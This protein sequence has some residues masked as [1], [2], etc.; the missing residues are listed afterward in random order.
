MPD[1]AM[2]SEPESGGVSPLPSNLK[3]RLISGSVLA[4]I[5]F[6]LVYAGPLPFA[7][8]VLLCGLVMSWEWGRLVRAASFDLGFFIHALAVTL[9]VVL[10]GAGYAALALATLVIAAITLI[11][12]YVGRGARLS[13]LG[14]FYVGLPAVSLLWMRSDEPFGFTAVLFIFAVVWSSD[15]AAYAAGRGI[16]GPK[17]MPRVSPNKTWAGL[18]GALTAG[19][20]VGA[21]FAGLEPGA[22]ALR[23]VLVG[24]GLALV[25]Q[26][27]DLAE[28]ALKRLFN[29]KD[30]SDLIPGHGGFMDRM[31]GLVAAAV[32]AALLA[33]VIDPHAPARALLFGF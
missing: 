10:A 1:K 25:A 24:V 22:G 27:G 17:L 13:A 19:A 6:A 20:I 33:L 5:A 31:D 23:L 15:T 26:A 28:S 3:L 7:V 12:L 18:I 32:T 8:L 29:L 16:G 2:A 21:V 30:A 11:P 4:A 14:V 9:A